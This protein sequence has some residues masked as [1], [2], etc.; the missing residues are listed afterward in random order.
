MLTKYLECRSSS[1]AVL[2][3]SNCF[4]FG[5]SYDSIPL[6]CVLILQQVHSG[7]VQNMLLSLRTRS[8]FL[9]RKSAIPREPGAGEDI[10]QLDKPIRSSSCRNRRHFVSWPGIMHTATNAIRT[11]LLAFGVCAAERSL[12]DSSSSNWLRSDMRY[13]PKLNFLPNNRILSYGQLLVTANAC[14]KRYV[15]V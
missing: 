9:S 15:I 8:H 10:H 2:L 7:C 3:F 6:Y 1:R 4:S 5:G 12:L 14:G 11:L 13:V